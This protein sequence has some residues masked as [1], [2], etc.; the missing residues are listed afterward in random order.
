MEILIA[1]TVGT[2]VGMILITV[3]VKI[4]TKPMKETASEQ[5]QLAKETTA[6]LQQ[7]N[8]DLMATLIAMY[9]DHPRVSMI[10]VK[11]LATQR[12]EEAKMPLFDKEEV[13]PVQ[14][15]IAEGVTVVGE[16]N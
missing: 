2:F 3:I 1:S 6:S 5:A 10:G 15:G 4:V 9:S 14:P 12:V 16:L 13:A 7:S 11:E 8:R